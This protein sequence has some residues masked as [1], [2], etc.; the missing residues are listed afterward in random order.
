MIALWEVFDRK[1]RKFERKYRSALRYAEG[2]ATTD[3][4]IRI[5]S[6]LHAAFAHLEILSDDHVIFDHEID[7][8]SEML[9]RSV[10]AL[11][12]KCTSNKESEKGSALFPMVQ[13][14]RISI[15]KF[16]GKIIDYPTFKSKFKML[17][18]KHMPPD[19]ALIRLRDESLAQG[20]HESML[21]KAKSSLPAAWQALDGHFGRPS[22]V[23]DA[24]LKELRE[25]MPLVKA[26][27]PSCLREL[28][29]KVISARD[30]LISVGMSHVLGDSA[31]PLLLTK[32]PF[33]LREKIEEKLL[34]EDMPTSEQIELF[35]SVLERRATILEMHALR[36]DAHCG[37]EKIAIR[38]SE[39]KTSADLQSPSESQGRRK[40]HNG[41]PSKVV[42]VFHRNA[43]N[44]H[45]TAECRT[46]RNLTPSEL[47]VI[48]SNRGLC[49]KCF[50]KHE[51][52]T[53]IS[54][55][56]C[57]KP[58]CQNRG[59][60]VSTTHTVWSLSEPTNNPSVIC[61]PMSDTPPGIVIQC[62]VSNPIVAPTIASRQ[63]I[64]ESEANET[65]NSCS[66]QP[67]SHPDCDS[68]SEVK[69]VSSPSLAP[70]APE[71]S[72]HIETKSKD[73]S[74]GL[75]EE[76]AATRCK[77][78]ECFTASPR[79]N[80]VFSDFATLAFLFLL[81]GAFSEL[82]VNSPAVS[83]SN[84]TGKLPLTITTFDA[85]VVVPRKVL[86][87]EI[88]GVIYPNHI[89]NS[90]KVHYD[91]FLQRVHR[92]VV[93]L[94]TSVDHLGRSSSIHPFCS[95]YQRLVAIHLPFKGYQ[96][97]QISP[98]FLGS[99]HSP[100]SSPWNDSSSFSRIPTG[101]YMIF[102]RVSIVVYSH[103]L[104]GPSEYYAHSTG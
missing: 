60:H 92:S 96:N 39:N 73:V 67:S 1:L 76:L 84:F 38:E 10:A 97:D 12:T 15:P 77:P 46:F 23:R 72:D 47:K 61:E 70:K 69:S 85:N 26:T 90:S 75:C 53:C 64:V 7:I 45:T 104:L 36:T 51:T 89:S 83:Y 94:P 35:I 19:I 87:N 28:V 48:F 82:H 42:C 30:D 50:G 68:R 54:T 52:R 11:A 22:F 18:E 27:E 86:V 34:D 25:I 29:G 59:T 3:D 71:F 31:M 63:F 98:N 43:R 2:E 14:E 56:I 58:D 16:S 5:K 49:L 65:S 20:S 40:L 66:Q 99:V 79:R 21:V 101:E 41:C 102:P 44:R 8:A 57:T 32:I 88:S 91:N 78:R 37:A 81:V 62:D 9:D 33:A 93:V 6:E 74:P 103:L 95:P 80:V 100:L 4:C 13:F 17:V 55:L 24:N